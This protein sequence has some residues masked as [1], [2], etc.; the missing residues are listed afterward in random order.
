MPAFLITLPSLAIS[1][2]IVA[3]SPSGELP[4]ISVL[5]TKN[6]E[7]LTKNE[8]FDFQ[9]RSARKPCSESL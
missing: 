7:L 3:A 4:T 2:F 9:A 1:A 6:N 8:I 5:A